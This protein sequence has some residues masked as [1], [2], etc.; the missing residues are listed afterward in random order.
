MEA[1]HVIRNKQD[2]L[3]VAVIEAEDGVDQDEVCRRFASSLGLGNNSGHQ[4]TACYSPITT[5]KSLAKHANHVDIANDIVEGV[6][7]HLS[8]IPVVS[9]HLEAMSGNDYDN[10]EDKLTEITFSILGRNP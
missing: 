5:W 9:N 8:S 3:I 7:T 4:L 10:L 1:V 2:G 6:L